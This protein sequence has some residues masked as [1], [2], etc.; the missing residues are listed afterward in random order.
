ML[1]AKIFSS[2]H[3]I[4]KASRKNKNW[5][6][7]CEIGSENRTVKREMKVLFSQELY[8]MW[9]CGVQVV[10]KNYAR[11]AQGCF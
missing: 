9:N 7:T 4:L 8:E 5:F 1:R 10:P 11:T 3:V 6:K 2:V